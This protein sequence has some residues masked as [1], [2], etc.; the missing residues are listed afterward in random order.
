MW[1]SEGGMGFLGWILSIPFL[2]IGLLILGFISTL[3]SQAYWDYRVEEMC[4]KDGGRT[5]YEKVVLSDEQYGAMLDKAGNIHIPSSQTLNGSE[6][7]F[8]QYESEKIFA[9]I[10]SLNVTKYSTRVIR[11]E[12]KNVVAEQIRYGRY[13]GDFPFSVSHGSSFM[14]PEFEQ[15]LFSEIFLKTN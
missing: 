3:I 14:C 6:K 9:G 11:R 1:R 13:G 15:G 4:K 10:L 2:L 8:Y 5:I 7:Y 12:G